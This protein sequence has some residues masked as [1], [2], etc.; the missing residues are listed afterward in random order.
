M[1]SFESLHRV[2]FQTVAIFE[3]E[4]AR[5]SR[6]VAKR[7][8]QIVADGPKE[9]LLLGHLCG[10]AMVYL[11][12]LRS[13]PADGLFQTR[14]DALDVQLLGL[15]RVGHTIE[16]VHE[17]ADFI[18]PL[19]VHAMGEISIRQR[20]SGIRETLDRDGNVTRQKAGNGHRD[21][22][23][24]HAGQKNG[25]LEI[26][27][28]RCVLVVGGTH[29]EVSVDIPGIAERSCAKQWDRHGVTKMSVAFKSLN[30]PHSIGRPLTRAAELLLISN[31]FSRLCNVPGQLV[32]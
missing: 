19:Y 9:I 32:H 28:L 22:Y 31:P 30:A 3:H 23:R 10:Q 16:G 7:G 27:K 24:G 21:Q 20:E 17:V 13:A 2:F 29:V 12:E 25:G 14:V 4:H 18:G 11:F 8:V 26:P 5:H 1:N 15:N 6:D